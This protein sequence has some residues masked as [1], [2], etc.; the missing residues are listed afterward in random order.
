MSEGNQIPPPP[1]GTSPAAVPVKSPERTALWRRIVV[2]LCVVL[3]CIFVSSGVAATW[4]KLTAL[5]TDTYVGTVGPIIQDDAVAE[6]VSTGVVQRVFDR[7]D[8]DAVVQSVLPAQAQSLASPLVAVIQRYAVQ[9]VDSIVKSDQFEA[10]WR[11]A[12]R[13]AHTQLVRLLK[14]ELVSS[15]TKDKANEVVLD[16]KGVVQQLDDRLQKLG[17]D[18]F[19]GRQPGTEVGQF[20]VATRAQLDKARQAVEL[21]DTIAWALPILALIFFVLAIVLSRRRPRTIMWIGLGTII[22][23]AI[24]AVILRITRR[25]FIGRIQDPLRQSA[26]DSIWG[27]VFHGLR[28]QV[29]VA[30]VLAAIVA[31]AGWF[32]GGSRAAVGGRQAISG[33]LARWGGHTTDG[34]PPGGFARFV[35]RFRRPIQLASVGIGLI[36]LLAAPKA[37]LGLVLLATLIVVVVLVLVELIAGPSRSG[38]APQPPAAGP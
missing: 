17:I 27:D 15:D 37:T 16:L 11:E 34:P 22:T 33:M 24:L 1:G 19:Q 30:V 7:V 31:L 23:L 12:N 5:D 13:V 10:I 26:A 3:G 35:D 29:V 9:L 2:P 32:L 36:V 25:N 28:V 18:L 14:G 8:V 21:L 6:A 4:V 38:D 20:V